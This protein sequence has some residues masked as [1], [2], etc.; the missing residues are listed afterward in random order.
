MYSVGNGELRKPIEKTVNCPHCGEEHDV[1]FGKNSITG[2]IS[3]L[4][5]FYKCPKTN[6][7][8]LYGIDGKQ[9]PRKPS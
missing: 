8:Y 5:A 6:K 3:K 1:E 4:L 2:E 7:T 9:I